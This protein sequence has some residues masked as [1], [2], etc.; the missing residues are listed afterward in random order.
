[1]EQVAVDLAVA[2]PRHLTLTVTA[3]KLL[4]IAVI[5]ALI[6]VGDAVTTARE[7]TARSAVV[8][9]SAVVFPPI[10]GLIALLSFKDSRAEHAVTTAVWLAQGVTGVGLVA[11]PIIAD[12]SNARVEDP[13][14]TATKDAGGSTEL[15]SI[16][17]LVTLLTGERVVDPIPTAWEL[18]ARSTHIRG[19]RVG[20]TSVTGLAYLASAVPTAHLITLCVTGLASFW[21]IITLLSGLGLMVS[22]LDHHTLVVTLDIW[23]IVSAW[24]TGLKLRV[25]GL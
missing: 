23:A 7:L 6:A 12:L 10:A 22:A 13:I 24:V 4:V 15:T 20:L 16:R 11:V 14:P 2:T 17:A 1:M 19:E 3:V 21:P 8:R 18:T 25:R 5:T 9:L